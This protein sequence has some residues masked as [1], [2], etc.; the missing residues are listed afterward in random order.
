MQKNVKNLKFGAE[1]CK[2]ILFILPIAKELP[3][4]S[5]LS[6][7]QTVLLEPSVIN[8]GVNKKIFNVNCYLK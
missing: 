8:R 4:I 1:K 3:K 6:H 7:F 5:K 2:M